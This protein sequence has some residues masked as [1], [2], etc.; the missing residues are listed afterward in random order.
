[1]TNLIVLAVL[2]FV[3]YFGAMY[4]LKRQRQRDAQ[5]PRAR[6]ISGMA[7]TLQRAMPGLTRQEA[8]QEAE[9]AKVDLE[10]AQQRMVDAMKAEGC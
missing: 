8:E 9:R 4:L 1:M 3:S 7:D 2:S 6:W 5:T 10:R